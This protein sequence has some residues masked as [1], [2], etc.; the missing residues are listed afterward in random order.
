ML[1]KED[2]E[3][4]ASWTMRGII[5]AAISL[6]GWTANRLVQTLDD[7]GKGQ[8]EIKSEVSQ[9]TSDLRV[10]QSAIESGRY[11]SLEELEW[12][13]TDHIHQPTGY[14]HPGELATELLSKVAH[15]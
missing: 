6:A 15:A 10:I 12:F 8:Q 5:I 11:R 14:R 13:L 4:I 3:G 1:S 2:I 9:H 7:Q